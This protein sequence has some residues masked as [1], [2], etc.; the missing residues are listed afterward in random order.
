MK[1]D[2]FNELVK[3]GDAVIVTDDFGK[4]HRSATRSIAWDI[5]SGSTLVH[6]EGFRSYSVERIKVVEF[7]MKHIS[8]ELKPIKKNKT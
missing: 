6:C 8:D 2:D 1:A 4:E 3:M 5:P 7:P